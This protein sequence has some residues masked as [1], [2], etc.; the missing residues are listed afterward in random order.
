LGE[1]QQRLVVGFLR[2]GVAGVFVVFG[3]QKI[4]EK[5]RPTSPSRRSGKPTVAISSS[6]LGCSR[7]GMVMSGRG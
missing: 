1:L 4:V 5:T 7:A 3:A 2:I 6:D